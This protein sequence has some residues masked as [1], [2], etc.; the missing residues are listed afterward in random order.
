LLQRAGAGA[1][2]R[3]GRSVWPIQ[4][5]AGLLALLLL[6][7][8]ARW[9]MQSI[10]RSTQLVSAADV[11]AM[12]WVRTNTAPDARFLVNSFPAYSG[13]LV[14]GTDAGWWLPLL[15][16][17]ETTLPP[18]TY[19]SERGP[20]PDYAHQVNSISAALRERALTDP[21]AVKVDL[22]TADAL[23]VLRDHK[24]SYV[25]SGAQ[26]FP[27]GVDRIDTKRLR[28][29][30]KFRLVYDRGGVQIFQLVRP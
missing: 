15:T 6:A 10:D 28:T 29:S 20:T 26:D 23:A 18:L 4:I 9:Q 14:A 24:I 7:W 21:R 3:I 8:G 16:G 27:T 13:Y 1:L 12:A 25:Y 19:G 30:A 22:T 2:R 11:D 17:R 5:F